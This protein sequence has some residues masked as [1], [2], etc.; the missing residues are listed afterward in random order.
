MN[1]SIKRK[2]QN[3]KVIAHEG[4]Y[5]IELNGRIPKWQTG[6]STIE[7][8][9][10]FIST[11]PIASATQENIGY[12]PDDVEFI[13]D[14]YGFQAKGN[15]IW[16]LRRGDTLFYLTPDED[17]LRMN[18]DTDGTCELFIGTDSIIERLDRGQDVFSA[19]MLIDSSDRYK[20]IECATNSRDMTKNMIRVKSSNL[21]S[22]G[23]SIK[24]ARSD[25]GDVVIQFKGRNG[26]P[27]DIYQYFEVPVRLWRRF[28]V[29]PSK[30]HFFWQ[31]LR[32]NFTYRKLT[33]D[34]KTH[35]KNGV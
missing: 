17:I 27:G 15:N 4:L 23:I 8:A 2:K 22:Y 3:V 16:T 29:A 13:I 32:N 14:T 20:V 24:D 6:F 10:K 11:H 25:K 7:C 21:W 34:R 28:I 12:S 31:Y 18:A 5:F 26:G 33:G 35:L 9:K 1:L 30:G 19:F